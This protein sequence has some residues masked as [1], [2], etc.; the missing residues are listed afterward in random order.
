MLSVPDRTRRPRVQ[1]N[2]AGYK[3]A[4]KNY[5]EGSPGELI[6]MMKEASLDS[7]A[8]G[9][10]IGRRAGFKKSYTLKAPGETDLPDGRLQF[11]RRV[12]QRLKVH[13]L[14]EA[15]HEG[16]LYLYTVID[17]EWEVEAGRQIP[18]RFKAFDQ[19][20]FQRTD[21][22]RLAVDR[23]GTLDPVPDTA[24][25]CEARDNP[26]M[27]PVLR[28]FI[29]KEFGLESWASFLETF[30]EPFVMAKYPPGADDD[31]KSEVDTALKQMAS[32][33]RGRAPKGTDF[34]V[35]EASGDTGDHATF[36]AR[37]NKGIAITLL[38][39]ENAASDEGGV[40]VGGQD[41]SFEVRH[42]VA[43]DDMLFIE[44]Y[45]N[46][47]IRLVGDQNFGDGAYPEFELNKNK[48]VDAKEHASILDTAYRHGARI[49]ISEYEKLGIRVDTE[50]Q[51]WI[52]RK[53]S[54]L[55]RFQFD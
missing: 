42:A 23:G 10:L 17:F 2:P 39:H 40:N 3:R 16:R 6:R 12:L 50:N 14:M 15:I 1:F 47:L 54:E 36:E 24:L 49:H 53:Q 31:F 35:R 52:Q 33:S 45:V 5:E 43:K 32:S 9:C 28:D 13:E 55:D 44:P 30:G 4:K 38:G 7:Y 8:N 22:G 37:S 41:G 48:P 18:T 34:E 11:F 51:E 27:L 29:L 21:E 20:H 26:L 25:V 19:Q 46:E